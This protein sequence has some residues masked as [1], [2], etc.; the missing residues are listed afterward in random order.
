M[1]KESCN[2][3]RFEEHC[4]IE[5]ISILILANKAAK[6]MKFTQTDQTLII[7]G[8]SGSGKTY[9]AKHAIDFLSNESELSSAIVMKSSLILEIF[10]NATTHMNSNSSRFSKYIEVMK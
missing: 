8:V 4:I 2:S 7:T 3:N 5:I 1:P 9:T 10:G 6:N